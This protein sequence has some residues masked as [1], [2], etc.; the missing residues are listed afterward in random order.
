MQI[1]LVRHGQTNWNKEGRYQGITDIPLNEDGQNEAKMA[2]DYLATKDWDCIVS[3]PLQRAKETAT[4]INEKVGTSLLLMDELVERSFGEAEGLL[5]HEIE[6][7]YGSLKN[8]PNYETTEMLNKRMIQAMERIAQLPYEKVIIVAHALVI[9]KILC[10][11]EHGLANENYH[12]LSNCGLSYITCQ[13]DEWKIEQINETIHLQS[14][15][16]IKS[17]NGLTSL[18]SK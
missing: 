4:I 13:N 15:K 17:F 3:S 7:T 6:P 1:V 10:I 8:I 18:A 16:D 14:L 2:R 11:I 9:N 12:T 5:Y